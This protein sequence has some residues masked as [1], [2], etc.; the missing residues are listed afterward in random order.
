[1]LKPNLFPAWLNRE[2]RYEPANN[3]KIINNDLYEFF[4]NLYDVCLVLFRYRQNGMRC[5]KNGVSSSGSN[6]CK[7]W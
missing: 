5:V 2:I 1:M 4:N 6:Y 7:S 3:S